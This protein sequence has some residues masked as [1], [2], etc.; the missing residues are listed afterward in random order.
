MEADKVN[1]TKVIPPE[2]DANLMAT[3]VFSTKKKDELTAI[4][5]VSQK[6]WASLN[7][8]ETDAPK[9]LSLHKQ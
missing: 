6:L 3:P 8:F 7:L 4:E 1:S 9:V 5:T 2:V